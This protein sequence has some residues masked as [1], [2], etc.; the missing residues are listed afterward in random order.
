[1]TVY[2]IVY[3]FSNP[4][5]IPISFCCYCL[6]FTCIFVCVLIYFLRFYKIKTSF[7]SPIKVK[8]IIFHSILLLLRPYLF[9]LY[10]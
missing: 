10:Q 6:N 9:K 1:M 5:N 8:D 4:I 7:S 3:I 2:N